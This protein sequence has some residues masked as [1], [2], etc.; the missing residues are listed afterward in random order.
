MRLVFR[1]RHG[2]PTQNMHCILITVPSICKL[3]GTS[4]GLSLGW[5]VL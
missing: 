2:A 4:K 3:I 5:I 1:Q